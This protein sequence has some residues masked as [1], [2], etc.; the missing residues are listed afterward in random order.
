MASTDGSDGYKIG[1]PYKVRG[2]W[3]KPGVNSKYQAIGLASWYGSGFHGRR[4]A[5]GEK[6][7][8]TSLTVAHPTLPMPSYVRVT[9]LQNGRSIV[10]RVNDRGPFSPTAWW[11]CRPASP[12]CSISSAAAPPR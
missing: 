6:F 7:D 12:R 1:K 11:T 3:Y 5:S 4:T 10:A 2:K 9:N 8:T